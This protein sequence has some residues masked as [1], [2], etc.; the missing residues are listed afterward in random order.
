[1]THTVHIRIK[2]NQQTVQNVSGKKKFSEIVALSISPQLTLDDN[3]NSVFLVACSYTNVV[4]T[5]S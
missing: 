5:I 3:Y 2:V 1:M 4:C